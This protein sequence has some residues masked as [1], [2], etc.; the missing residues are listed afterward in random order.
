M[1]TVKNWGTT[2]ILETFCEFAFS[3]HQIGVNYTILYITSP[4][5][6]PMLRSRHLFFNEI[7]LAC[8][9]LYTVQCTH[10]AAPAPHL[11]ECRID[12]WKINKDH[13]LVNWTVSWRSTPPPRGRVGNEWR[14]TGHSE[15]TVH[16]NIP[17][18]DNS[19]L[20]NCLNLLLLFGCYEE[21]L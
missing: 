11:L 19:Q 18:H 9:L 2:S 20:K 15:A 21:T 8:T 16:Y 13:F 7:K 12:V 4:S 17:V 3:R 14:Q 1:K 6:F 10:V 5:L